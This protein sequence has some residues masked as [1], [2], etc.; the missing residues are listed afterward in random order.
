MGNQLVL[1]S[2]ITWDMSTIHYLIVFGKCLEE[3]YL[4]GESVSS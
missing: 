4:E 3:F 1:Y 2:G